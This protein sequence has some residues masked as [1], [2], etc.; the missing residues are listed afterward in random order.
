MMMGNV[1]RGGSGDVDMPDDAVYIAR[2]PCGCV[3]SS[4]EISHDDTDALWLYLAQGNGW[5]VEQVAIDQVIALD[6][7]DAAA[8]PGRWQQTTLF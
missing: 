8:I 6:C 7:Q 1:W 2:L 5:T 3:V 4:C